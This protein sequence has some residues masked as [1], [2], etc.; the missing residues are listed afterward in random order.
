MS[1]DDEEEY[2][3]KMH[4]AMQEMDKRFEFVPDGWFLDLG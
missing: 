3:R 4:N 2:M 1:Q